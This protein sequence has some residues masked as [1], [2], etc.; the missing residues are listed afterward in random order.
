MKTFASKFIVCA[1]LLAAA[2]GTAYAQQYKLRIAHA[3]APSEPIHQVSLDFAKAVEQR[4]Q[5][6][7]QIQVFPSEQLGI[8]KD[9]LEQVRQG[10]PII[11]IADAGFMSDYVADFGV[12]NGPYLISDPADFKK[13][14]NS[15]IY[16]DMLDKSQKAG[17]HPLAFNFYFG[18]RNM[19][20]RKPFRSPADLQG[21]TVRIPP[22]PLWVETFKALGARG[23]PL[24]WTE[25]YSAL[26]QNV[27]DAVE[28]PMA[29]LVAAKLQEERK[30]LSVTGHFTQFLGYVMNEKTF[31]GY[32]ADIQ[33]VLTEEA[34]KAGERMTQ[35]TIENDKK[36]MEDLR[37]QGVTVVTDI[38]TKSFRAATASVY[39][40]F[41]KWTPGLYAKV[42]KTLDN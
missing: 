3:L 25:V 40:A 10:A 13:L 26:A 11:Q 38:D 41:P 31:R 9:M 19:L 30:V 15:D 12:L 20:G 6:R 29:S 17:L 21:V 24:P 4:T 39:G 8:N 33:K 2:T 1:A 32:P 22:N 27:V 37:K 7:V 34:Q 42:R 14:L 18:S 36:L 35:T 16:R 28:A 5:G 23:T